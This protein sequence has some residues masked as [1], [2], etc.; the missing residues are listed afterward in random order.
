WSVPFI[1]TLL[2]T[3]I[4]G[5]ALALL[6]PTRKASVLLVEDDEGHSLHVGMWHSRSDILF[7]RQ[8]IEVVRSAAGEVEDR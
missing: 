6:V 7:K 4:L 2:I 1:Y 8:V 3:A 5:L